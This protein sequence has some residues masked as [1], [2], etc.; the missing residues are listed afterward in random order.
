M[1][2]RSAWRGG[3]SREQLAP[4][5]ASGGSIAAMAGSLGVSPT[6]VRHWL[7]RYGLRTERTTR[8]AATKAAREGGH[9]TAV[10]ICPVHGADSVL[11]PR[12]D[13]FRCQRCRSDAVVARRRRVKAMLLE[14]AG[15]ACVACGY[16]KSSAALHFH[17]LDPSTKSFSIAGGGVSRSLARARAEAAKCVLL[18]ANCHAEVETGAR[19]L[20]SLPL[21]AADR[22][23]SHPG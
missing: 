3:L 9:A 18:C 7:G 8:L 6:T 17:H 10:A 13:G 4:L 12:G 20:P 19:Q 23:G 11:V 2:G 14:E 22:G 21:P 16:A 1:G 5:V 15:G